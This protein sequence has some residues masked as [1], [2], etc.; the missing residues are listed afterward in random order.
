[1]DENNLE[2][3]M[4]KAKKRPN[5]LP[6]AEPVNGPVITYQLTPEQLAAY[7]PIRTKR[8]RICGQEKP[9]LQFRSRTG[10]HTLPGMSG[11]GDECRMCVEK[12]NFDQPP[13]DEN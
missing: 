8:C 13:K 2:V 5:P 11:M 12:R 6:A 1:L 10:L 7:G 4:R 3:A 9:M